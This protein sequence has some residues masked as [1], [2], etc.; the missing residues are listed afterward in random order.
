MSGAMPDGDGVEHAYHATIPSNKTQSGKT[1]MWAVRVT[2]NDGKDHH[3]HFAVDN[4]VTPDV[5][6]KQHTEISSKRGQSVAP[7]EA[8]YAYGDTQAEQLGLEHHGPETML[9]VMHHFRNMARNLSVGHRI[10]I[11]PGEVTA[12]TPE[13]VKKI[14]DRKLRAYRKMTERATRGGEWKITSP[15]DHPTIILS[16]TK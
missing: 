9:H 4:N 15:P 10:H 1:N 2:S 3:F 8:F 7:H 6:R 14:R 13:S 16:R 12:D 11:D 5:L